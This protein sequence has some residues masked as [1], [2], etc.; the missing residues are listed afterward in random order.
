MGILPCQMYV[1]VIEEM[2]PEFPTLPISI[3]PEVLPFS[4]E[5]PATLPVPTGYSSCLYSATNPS[6]GIPPPHTYLSIL[7]LFLRPHP[8]KLQLTLPSHRG[9]GLLPLVEKAAGH[10]AEAPLRGAEGFS[11]HLWGALLS[12]R[13]AQATDCP[14]LALD[15]ATKASIIFYLLVTL[16]WLPDQT[17]LSLL[18]LEPFAG[19]I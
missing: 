16:L 6:Q 4:P 13:E 18:S 19:V 8:L 10:R 17:S 11:S 12:G 1:N 2:S 5:I 15:I 9:P 3:S 14:M 7:L